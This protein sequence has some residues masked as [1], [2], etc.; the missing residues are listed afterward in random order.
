MTTEQLLLT[1]DTLTSCVAAGLKLPMKKNSD[2]RP[3]AS[4]TKG[5]NSKRRRKRRRRRNLG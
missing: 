1:S 3:G 4:F 5:R 2:G